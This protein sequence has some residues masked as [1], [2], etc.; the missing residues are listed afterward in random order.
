MHG[1]IQLLIKLKDEEVNL[2]PNIGKDS[3]HLRLYAIPLAQYHYRRE[4][5]FSHYLSVSL[6]RIFKFLFSFPFTLP[7]VK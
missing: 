7:V 1:A 6:Y 4:I 3:L 5:C 2:L